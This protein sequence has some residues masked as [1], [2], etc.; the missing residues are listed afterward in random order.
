[1]AALSMVGNA[2]EQSAQ[3]NP[4]VIGISAVSPNPVA[5]YASFSVNAVVSGQAD[6]AV[7]DVA[8]RR[9]ANIQTGELTAG[10][11]AFSWR[12]PDTMGSGIYFVRASMN[13]QTVSSRM[14]V[15]R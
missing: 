3:V 10:P 4:A 12:I 1:M 2:E 8:G 7:Y 15:V 11:N 5:A 13:G 6:I 9:A 14:T